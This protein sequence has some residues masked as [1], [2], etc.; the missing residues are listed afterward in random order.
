MSKLHISL[1]KIHQ[2]LLTRAWVHKKDHRTVGVCTGELFK[3]QVIVS[4][5]RADSAG[6]HQSLAEVVFSILIISNGVFN[7]FTC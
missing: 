3:R 7:S 1:E 6:S 2:E 4:E 5:P